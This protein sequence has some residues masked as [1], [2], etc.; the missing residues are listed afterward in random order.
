MTGSEIVSRAEPP[1]SKGFSRH[2]VTPRETAMISLNEKRVL[3]YW[4]LGQ[5]TV[6]ISKSLGIGEA[7]ICELLHSAR[8][9]IKEP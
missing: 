3:H 2:L 1:L 5:D 7:R 9:K 4:R 6:S 8:L